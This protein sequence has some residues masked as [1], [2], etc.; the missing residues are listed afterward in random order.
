M[1]INLPR[2]RHRRTG[3]RGRPPSRRAPAHTGGDLAQHLVPLSSFAV[4]SYTANWA[5][6]AFAALL[7]E[8]SP[9]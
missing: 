6:V 9:P 5:Y 7:L 4:I 8:P 1:V 2:P 3:R